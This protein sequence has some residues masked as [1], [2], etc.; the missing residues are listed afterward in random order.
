MTKNRINLFLVLLLTVFC[1]GKCKDKEP[2]TKEGLVRKAKALALKIPLEDIPTATMDDADS[3]EGVKD[4]IDEKNKEWRK[5]KDV[6]ALEQEDA[7][8]R[9]KENLASGKAKEFLQT[10]RQLL[11]FYIAKLK[12]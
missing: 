6:S 9:N 8:M 12:K 4:Y 11:A 1:A 3:Q 10:M 2:K 7:Q 5:A